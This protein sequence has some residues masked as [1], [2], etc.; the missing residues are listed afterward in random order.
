MTM[1]SVSTDFEARVRD[2]LEA[3]S[4]LKHPFYVEWTQGTL[5]MS[6]MQDYARQYYHFEAAFPRLLSAIHTRT[7]SPAIR[8]LILDNLWDEEHGDRN[9]PVLWLEFAKA[10]GVDADDV[11]NARL[12]PETVALVE[13]FKGMAKDAPLAEA[14]GTLFAYEGQVPAIA[15]R[16]IKGL[17]EFYNLEPKQFEFFSVHLVADIAHSG[18]EMEA[19]A[20]S[21]EDE[22]AVLRAVD[23]ACDRL[24]GFLDG[25][26]AGA[27]A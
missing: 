12:R 17:T 9:H 25:C 20:E 18:A 3:K 4:M 23:A 2:V 10:V 1:M 7:E 16:K 22:A 24:L 14:L 21:C 11:M 8:Q 26:Y 15:W 13:H 6:K 27:A 5:P 19:I